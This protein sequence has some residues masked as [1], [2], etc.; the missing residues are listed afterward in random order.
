MRRMELTEIHDHPAFPTFLRDLVTDALQA[1]WDFGNSYHPILPRLRAALASARTQQILDLCSGAGGP[2]L[3]LHQAL[4]TTTPTPINIRLTDKY[5]NQQAFE[6]AHAASPTISFESRSVD[7]AQ[8]PS[9]LPGF[10]TIFSAFHHFEPPQAHNVLADA[11]HRRQGI[12]VFEAAR[13]TP[14]TMLVLCLTPMIVV[15]LT[16]RIRPFS[17]RRLFF[18][19]VVPVV[20]FVIWYDGIVSCLR[21]YPHQ[22]L[23]DLVR[24]LSCPTYHWDIGEERGGLLPVTYLIGRPTTAPA[25]ASSATAPGIIASGAIASA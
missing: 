9:D 18:T 2:W 1:L 22:Q 16:L 4:Q 15:L 14:W 11:F 8:V 5:P 3:S 23:R 20:P 21:A 7:A 19:L 25:S 13:P 10:R 24:D 12:A 17:W 6:R